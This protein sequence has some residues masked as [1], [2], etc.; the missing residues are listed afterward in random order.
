LEDLTLQQIMPELSSHQANGWVVR[1]L[2]SM[3]SSYLVGQRLKALHREVRALRA[4][5]PINRIRLM[6]AEE[7]FYQFANRLTELTCEDMRL[8]TYH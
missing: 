8:L 6:V 1:E 3:S 4:A 5:T 2:D 7:M